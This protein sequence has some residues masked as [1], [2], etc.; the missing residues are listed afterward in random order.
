MRQISMKSIARRLAESAWIADPYVYDS[1]KG[2]NRRLVGFGMF[3]EFWR[4]I[5]GS[6]FN[7]ESKCIFEQTFEDSLKIHVKLDGSNII[8][9]SMNENTIGI[10]SYKYQ[11]WMRNDDFGNLPREM[12]ELK[13]LFV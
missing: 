11:N 9:F 5:N 6:E 10:Q 13:R 3:E 7:I 8:I 2:T 4:D 12:M 1:E